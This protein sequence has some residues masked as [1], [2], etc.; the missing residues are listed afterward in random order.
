MNWNER[1]ADVNISKTEMSRDRNSPST[2]I[3]GSRN[4]HAL[5]LYFRC[6]EL[7]LYIV[8]V[9]LFFFPYGATSPI[10]ASAYLHETFRFHFSLL[11]LRHSVGLLGRVISPSQGLYLY[12]NTEKSTHTNTKKT[13]P[14]GDSNPRSRVPSERRQYTP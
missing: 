10:G 14:D 6:W 4:I 7:D 9:L 2:A 13:C 3:I 8:V 5:S 11:D 1:K 12:T